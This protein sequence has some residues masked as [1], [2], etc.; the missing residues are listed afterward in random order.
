MKVNH[1][2]LMSITSNAMESTEDYIKTTKK[3]WR[4]IEEFEERAK[5]I[6]NKSRYNDKNNEALWAIH[7]VTGYPYDVLYNAVRVERNYEK[8]NKYEKCLFFGDNTWEEEKREKL[9][10]CLSAKSPDDLIG[11]YNN[12]FCEKA[13]DRIHRKYW[14]R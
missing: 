10:K 1:M 14:R 13:I 6:D 2:W 3:P 9:F 8:R 12:E 11:I 4:T 7:I 5:K